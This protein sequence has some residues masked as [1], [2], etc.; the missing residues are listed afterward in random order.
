MDELSSRRFFQCLVAEKVLV[1]S[2]NFEIAAALLNC[3]NEYRD[4]ISLFEIDKAY[5]L[6]KGLFISFN[7]LSNTVTCKN[8]I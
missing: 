7:L 5:Q 4:R 6:E 3:L 8:P 2:V 1:E